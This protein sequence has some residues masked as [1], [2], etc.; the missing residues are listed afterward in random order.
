M[1]RVASKKKIKAIDPFSK[2]NLKGIKNIDKN[3][4][5]PPGVKRINQNKKKKG[6]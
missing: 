6:L 3:H 4:D 5:D 2:Q 1:G